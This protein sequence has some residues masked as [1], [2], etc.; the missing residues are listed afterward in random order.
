MAVYAFRVGVEAFDESELR[1]GVESGL[2]ANH[3]ELMFVEGAFEDLEG[4]IW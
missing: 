1:G 4:L 2:P 3:E